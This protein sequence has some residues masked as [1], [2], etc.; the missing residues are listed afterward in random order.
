MLHFSHPKLNLE[1]FGLREGMVFIDV[2]CGYGFYTIPAAEIVGE[3]GKVYAVDINAS[4]IDR[5]KREVAEKKLTNITAKVDEAEKTIF[6]NKCADIVFCSIVLHDFRAPEEVLDNAKH[7]LK[8]T[9]KLIN[10]DWKKKRTTVGPPINIRFSSEKAASLIKKAGFTIESV[11]DLEQDFY[12]IT[13]K[14]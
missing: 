11:R 3:K 14:P 4:Y 9:G 10:M 6:C 8:Q 13:A 7:M 2:G 1:H 5:L 12:I